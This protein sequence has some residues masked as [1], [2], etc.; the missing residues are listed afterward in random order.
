MLFLSSYYYMCIS[1]IKTALILRE[2]QINNE[3]AVIVQYQVQ[4]VTMVA[5][6][7]HQ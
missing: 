2:P 7:K 5:W 3:R 1:V 4:L 6:L